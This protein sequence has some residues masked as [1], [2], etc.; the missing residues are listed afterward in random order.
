MNV[1]LFVTLSSSAINFT[2][3][4]LITQTLKTNALMLAALTALRRPKSYNVQKGGSNQFRPSA[5]PV[6]AKWSSVSPET[7]KVRTHTFYDTRFPTVHI[8]LLCD[9]LA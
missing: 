8:S 9:V 5:R 1:N 3:Q 7:I 2:D 6:C 4:Y